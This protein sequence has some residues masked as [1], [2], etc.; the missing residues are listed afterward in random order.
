VPTEQPPPTESLV[1]E[2]QTSVLAGGWIPF[3][4]VILLSMLFSFLYV[5]YYQHKS[6]KEFGTTA[7]AMVGMVIALLT[8]ALI[9]VDIFLVS[10]FKNS[11]GT[12]HDWATDS[13]RSEVLSTL[14]DG[15]YAMYGLT[16]FFIFFLM[17]LSYFFF[18]EK[19]EVANVSTGKRLLGAAKFT[20][21]TLIVMAVLM[22]IGAFALNSDG[23]NCVPSEANGTDVQDWTK[24]RAQYAEESLAKN[25]GTN[26]LSFTIGV[27]AVIGMGYFV[28]YTSAG[29]VML[30]FDL[31]RSR[32]R[33]PD[34]HHLQETTK[35]V[36]T[37]REKQ[38]AMRA[39]YSGRIK[40]MSDRD[41]DQLADDEEE[42][43]VLLSA[44]EQLER[45]E[46]SCIGKTGRVLRPF[47]AIFGVVFLL[48][49]LFLVIALLLTSIDRLTQITSQHLNYETG[50]SQA[51]PKLIN[52]VDKLMTLLQLAFPMDYIAMALLVFYFV[53][54]TAVG[55]S[56]RGIRFCF[57]KVFSVRASKTVPQALLCLV[58]VLMFTVLAINVVL[59]S[60]APQYSTYGNQKYP[61]MPATV[62][63]VANF[64][65][66][67]GADQSLCD[68]QAPSYIFYVYNA[69]GKYI[70][71][72]DHSKSGGA[73]HQC[74]PG[75]LVSGDAVLDLTL[76]G[77]A[78]MEAC[79]STRLS[80]LMHAFF[81][82]AWFFGAIY[83]WANWLFI[84]MFFL[85][86]ILAVV[87][88]RK[89][90]FERLVNDKRTDFDDDDA[91]APFNP[92]WMR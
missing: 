88:K 62:Q 83:Y 41:R 23:S 46:N 73:P 80:A 22:C 58:S 34:L 67:G 51:A 28:F 89:S 4:I 18:E 92:S 60:L 39:K 1:G 17:P 68:S 71:L 13:I 65:A 42:E 48:L 75:L 11:D 85:N 72:I 54:S 45:N 3:A 38:E 90:E 27:L 82:N 25:G 16:C 31:F 84:L 44:S 21:G 50:Y 57:M 63:G 5:R 36:R 40:K 12:F 77:C 47:S 2:L 81:F 53:I 9:P 87:R 59:L 33:T 7:V 37:S 29:L 70:T 35:K 55:V 26:S 32:T 76:M 79:V 56:H 61:T 74:N 20:L 52:P 15:Y 30:P 6:E 66:W 43:R 10:S 78:K 69:S 49:S 24:C 14:T 64:T 8:T 91:P 19:D 86:L